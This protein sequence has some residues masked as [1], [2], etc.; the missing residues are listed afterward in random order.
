MASDYPA[1]HSAAS[2]PERVCFVSF[3]SWQTTSSQEG[4]YQQSKFALA[5]ETASAAGFTTGR[6]PAQ[7]TA[8][9]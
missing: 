2:V 8:G 6:S 9:R 1:R 4:E 3:R 7:E 5:T